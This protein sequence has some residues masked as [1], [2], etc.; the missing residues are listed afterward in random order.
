MAPSSYVESILEN[1]AMVA[2]NIAIHKPLV[3]NGSG[4]FPA[5]AGCVIDGDK[6]QFKASTNNDYN[7]G[8]VILDS[9]YASGSFSRVN[10]AY[11]ENAPRV[12][13]VEAKLARSKGSVDEF[14]DAIPTA[15]RYQYHFKNYLKMQPPRVAQPLDE[16]CKVTLPSDELTRL[17]T[18]ADE[19][20]SISHSDNDPRAA[21]M[22]P[23]Q[24]VR[25]IV[26]LLS[27]L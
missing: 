18:T 15:Y 19:L 24:R 20:M 26:Q 25:L 22:R 3:F 10:P 12:F 4:A 27:C 17:Q 21:N 14:Y 1:G 16:W 7:N 23:L 11:D 2:T 13:D 9:V 6:W 5:H 8:D